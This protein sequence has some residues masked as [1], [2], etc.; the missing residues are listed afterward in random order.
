[1]AMSKRERCVCSASV[2]H[3]RIRTQAARA[4][5]GGRPSCRRRRCNW[6]RLASPTCRATKCAEPICP[7]TAARWL[8]TARPRR[9]CAAG[10]AARRVE[11]SPPTV[12]AI[13]TPGV[14]LQS[15]RRLGCCSA[16]GTPLQSCRQHV[17][18]Q[19]YGHAVQAQQAGMKSGSGRAKRHSQMRRPLRALSVSSKCP[20]SRGG[21]YGIAKEGCGL[22][23][24]RGGRR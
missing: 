3:A 17:L 1:M 9:E 10:R 6:W 16:M 5:M 24:R 11:R 2:T 22:R 21:L 14:N 12:P 13:A 20:L 15:A 23:A 4:S 19:F 7:R 18:G 8:R